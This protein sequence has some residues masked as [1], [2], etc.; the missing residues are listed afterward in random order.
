[1]RSPIIAV[2]I[3]A[4]PLAVIMMLYVLV[5]GKALVKFFQ[6]QDESIA[7]ITQKT[8]FSILAIASRQ[9]LTGDKLAWNL[10]IGIILGILVPLLLR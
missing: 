1:M 4:I 8:L 7:K 3:S 10:A 9:P 6:G 2:L 5:R